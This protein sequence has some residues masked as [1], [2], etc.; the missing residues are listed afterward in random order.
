MHPALLDAFRRQHPID[1]DLKGWPFAHSGDVK[2]CSIFYHWQG[3]G[4]NPHVVFGFAI[5][6]DVKEYS[7]FK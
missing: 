7:A 2:P 6:I 1:I 4:H 3:V 5:F